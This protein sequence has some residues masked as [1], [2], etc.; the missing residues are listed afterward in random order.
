MHTLLLLALLTF[1]PFTPR[2]RPGQHHTRTYHARHLAYVQ[3]ARAHRLTR[4]RR[5]AA[6]ASLI[7]F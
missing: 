7:H 2:P 6:H 3:Q 4:Q 5:H 1:W